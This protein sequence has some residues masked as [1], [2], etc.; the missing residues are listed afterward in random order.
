MVIKNKIKKETGGLLVT[1]QEAAEI[2]GVSRTR[3]YQWIDEGR[4]VKHEMYGRTLVNREE[5]EKIELLTGGW[6]KGKPRKEPDVDAKAATRPA[7]ASNDCSTGKKK[8]GKI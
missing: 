2:R 5:L 7:R 3:I 8:A 4:L 1:V 6:P